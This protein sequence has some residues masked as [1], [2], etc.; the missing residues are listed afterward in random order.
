MGD[1]TSIEKLYNIGV[2]QLGCKHETIPIVE[3]RDRQSDEKCLFYA[4]SKKC[5]RFGKYNKV[6]KSHVR[7]DTLQ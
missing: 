1:L 3:K 7:Q 4:K 2:E 5:T 6:S